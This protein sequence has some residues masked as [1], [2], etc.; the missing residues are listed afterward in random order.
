MLYCSSSEKAVA[1]ERLAKSLGCPYKEHELL[2]ENVDRFLEQLEGIRRANE[3]AI[4]M[5]VGPIDFSVKTQ[6]VTDYLREENKR[7]YK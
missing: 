1:A 5:G 6:S 2:F 4:G 3:L 7:K